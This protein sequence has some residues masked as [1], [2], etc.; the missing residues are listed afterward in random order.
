MKRK[1]KF[2][3]V[4]FERKKVKKTEKRERKLCLE[5]IDAL[6]KK[7]ADN[8]KHVKV[9]REKIQTVECMYYLGV[10]ATALHYHS[11]SSGSKQ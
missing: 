6:G 2:R 5:G 7:F 4:K 8:H 9:Q 10:F 11:L 1:K 3:R